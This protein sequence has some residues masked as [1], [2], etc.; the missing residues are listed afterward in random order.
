MT[1]LWQE[2]NF[3]NQLTKSNKSSSTFGLGKIRGQDFCH[4]SPLCL[5]LSVFKTTLSYPPSVLP[6]LVMCE[7]LP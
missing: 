6:L 4:H 2:L 5:K 7:V 3:E 1:Y